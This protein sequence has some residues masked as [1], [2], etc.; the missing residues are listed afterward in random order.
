VRARAGGLARI[1]KDQPAASGVVTPATPSGFVTAPGD[2]LDLRVKAELVRMA[3]LDSRFGAPFGMVVAVIFAWATY[4]AF[5]PSVVLGWLALTLGCNTLRLITR[6]QYLRQAIPLED[7]QR[8]A[9]WFT[10][11]RAASGLSWGV[12]AWLF[13][14]PQESIYRVMVVLVLAGMTTGASRLLAPI[15]AAN[16]S[17]VYLAICP[18]VVRMMVTPDTRSYVLAAMWLLYVSYITVAAVQ[19]LRALRRTIRLHHENASLVGS[20]GAAK[21]QAERGNRDLSAEIARRQ[22]VESELRA[23]SERAA[24][25]SHAKSDFLATMSHEIRTP[26]NG[27]IGMLRIVRDT[28]LTQSQRDHIETAATSAETLLDLLNDVLDF[29][30]IEAGRLEL[31]QIAFSPTAV[32][33]SVADLLRPRAMSKGLEFTLELD[34]RLPFGV[35]GDPTRI[36]QVLFNL[37]GNAIKFTE[38]GRVTCG[39]SCDVV[40]GSTTTIRFAVSDTGIGIDSVALGRIFRPFTQADS[41]MS[42]RFG[43][44]GLGLAISQKLVAAMGSQLAVRSELGAGSVF[45][46]AVRF[47][48]P[49]SHLEASDNSAPRYVPPKLRGR[50]LIVEDDRINQRVI[51][52]FLKQMGLETGLAEDGIAA[53]ESALREPWDAI[54]MDCHLPRL[55]GL[56]AT[57]QIRA[58]HPRRDLPII[59]L[60][61]N[62]GKEDRA[63]CLAAG[64]DDFLTK[65][66]RVELL[67]AALQRKLPPAPPPE[68]R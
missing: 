18:L 42:R 9:N 40:D 48:P 37:I 21:E 5:P 56:D 35:L 43:G 1:S 29:S 14:T 63:A 10:V 45:E 50:I 58:R 44:T 68:G 17:Y 65:P 6:W 57:R 67:A 24:A 33:R 26:M 54:L 64:M 66:V 8:W 19:Q 7:T 51:G 25:A 12:G 30:K 61:A 52:H 60:T 23:A 4:S 55:D 13:Y 46:F 20:L 28:P 3:Y 38:R 49:A 15:A 27:I 47:K 53:V 39:L 16:L 41:S 31:E 22:I 59:A 11:V 62:A 34:P 2:A 36:R 32:A